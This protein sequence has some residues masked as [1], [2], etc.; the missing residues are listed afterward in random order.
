MAGMRDIRVEKVV[1]NIGVGEAGEK[2]VKAQKVLEVVT[3]QKS[4][5]TLS[6]SAVRDWGVRRNMP[7]GTRVT[8]RGDAA[9]AFLKEA[10]SIRNNRLPSYSFDPRGN[11]S[12]GIQDYTD[13]PGMKYDPEIGVFGM[14]VSVSLMRPGW[15]VAR[16]ALVRRPIPRRHRITKDEGV[17]FLQ[18]HFK[19]EVVE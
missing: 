17:R 4:I 18:D 11:F 16:R 13:F 15:R 14:D 3:K 2:L 8:L 9:E 1:V 19:V 10:L 7:I 5:Q 6:H 12:F